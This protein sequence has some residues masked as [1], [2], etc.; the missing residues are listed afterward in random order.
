MTKSRHI[1]PP[2]G[3]LAVLPLVPL[4]GCPYPLGFG[5]SVVDI[6]LTGPIPDLTGKPVAVGE[7]VELEVGFTVGTDIGLSFE[8]GIVHKV[9]APVAPHLFG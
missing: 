3:L 8:I 2:P 4:A 6:A 9:A 7:P 5:R 1:G